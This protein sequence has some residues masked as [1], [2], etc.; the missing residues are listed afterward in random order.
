MKTLITQCPRCT[1]SLT[2]AEA[3]EKWC[4]CC[5]KPVDRREEAR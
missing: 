1:K 2:A 4:V 5:A 3:I